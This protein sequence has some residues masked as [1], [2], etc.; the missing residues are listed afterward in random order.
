MCVHLLFKNAYINQCNLAKIFKCKHVYNSQNGQDHVTLSLLHQR[1]RR[2]MSQLVYLD[3]AA[4]LNVTKRVWALT[5]DEGRL[6]GN[7]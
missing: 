4:V 3:C 7:H 1:R 6:A 5:N 2:S